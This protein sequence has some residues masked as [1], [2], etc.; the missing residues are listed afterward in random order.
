MP[1]LIDFRRRIR[2]VKNTQQITRAMKF[3]AAARL[4]KA[5]ERV[6]ASR[7]YA[8]QI[9]RVLRS[10]SGRMEQ[11]AHPLLT[12]PEGPEKKPLVII[13]SAD[14]G[15]CGAFNTNVLRKTAEFLR[16]NADKKIELVAVGR[17]A[18]DAMRRTRLPLK[19]EMV[20]VTMNVKFSDAQEL[21]ALAVEAFTGG[22]ADAVYLI[23]NEFKN[24]LVQRLVVW[25]LL[26]IEP[27]VVTGPRREGAAEPAHIAG[28]A[29][30]VDYIYEQPPKEIFDRLVPR[31]VDTEVFRALLESSAAEHAA[32]MTAM[33]AATNNASELIDSLT[34]HMNK[35]RQAAITK[36]IIEVVSGAASAG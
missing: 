17:R 26:P 22:E 3:V 12:R 31:Y 25:R 29:A 13:I 14:R 6:L 1:T 15:L 18:R 27:E 5:Q 2:S 33:D 32:R 21:A 19:A 24:V 11:V 34:L 23:Y 28:Q 10:A 8:R 4:R 35:V 7:P 16:A 30:E 9:L 36:E 20:N